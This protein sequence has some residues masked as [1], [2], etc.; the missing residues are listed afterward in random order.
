MACRD[1]PRLGAPA[2]RRLTRRDGDD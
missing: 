1:A 2:D